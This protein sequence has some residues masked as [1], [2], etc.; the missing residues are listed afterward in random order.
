M[1]GNERHRLD[2]FSEFQVCPP[3]LD[4]QTGSLLDNLLRQEFLLFF[5]LQLDANCL[6]E[7]GDSAHPIQEWLKKAQKLLVIFIL[8]LPV[9]IKNHKK[10]LDQQRHLGTLED[11]QI[12]VFVIEN[13][14]VEC[15]LLLT[16][17]EYLAQF[18]V[19]KVAVALLK[20]LELA[21]G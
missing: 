12:V 2:P 11:Q 3:R 9:V 13:H 15:L 20:N 4:T 7:L 6:L 21:G 16:V 5:P 10:D 8:D 19:A 18:L 14:L 17:L 1:F